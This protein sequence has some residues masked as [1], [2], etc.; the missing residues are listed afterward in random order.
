MDRRKRRATV[1]PTVAPN[2]E[3]K[4][5]DPSTSGN[6]IQFGHL[7][8]ENFTAAP[9]DTISADSIPDSPSS[10][11]NRVALRQQITVTPRFHSNPSLY[12][13]HLEL[14]WQLDHTVELR[15]PTLRRVIA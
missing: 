13:R 3:Y 15:V 14:L 6:S 10:T 2:Q 11:Q 8:I 1:P 9:M 4:R 12:R 7:W 5:H